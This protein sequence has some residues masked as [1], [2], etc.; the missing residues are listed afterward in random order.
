M[1]VT[2]LVYWAAIYVLTYGPGVGDSETARTYLAL[3]GSSAQGR[4]RH[5]KNRYAVHAHTRHAW[6][7]LPSS[8]RP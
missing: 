4:G 7:T 5:P 6:G 1:R 2:T 3:G 8:Q